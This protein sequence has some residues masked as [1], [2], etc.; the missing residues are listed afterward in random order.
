M[1]N[2]WATKEDV[3]IEGLG[4]NQFIFFFTSEEDKVRILVGSP[5]HYDNSLLLLIEPKGMGE[6]AK[7]DFSKATFWVQIHNIPIVCM[8]QESAFQLGCKIGR[9]KEI[10]LGATGNCLGKF[11]RVRVE[12]DITK[13]LEKGILVDI[14]EQEAIPLI[15][16]Y[17][18]MP[19][20]CY[21]CGKIGHTMREC[22][23]EDPNRV[24]IAGAKGKYADWLK[25]PPPVRNKKPP[26]PT[27]KNT[28]K[29]QENKSPRCPSYPSPSTTKNLTSQPTN[30]SSNPSNPNPLKHQQFQHKLSHV[31]QPSSPSKDQSFKTLENDIPSITATASPSL[32]TQNNTTSAISS[33]S[34][35]PKQYSPTKTQTNHQKYN[36]VKLGKIIQKIILIQLSK[37]K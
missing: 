36:V 9:V 3:A 30:I 26:N 28:P 8:N 16:R 6:I 22:P 7:L 10:D 21:D 23:D 1:S 24:L 20:Y 2:I 5:W 4:D 25:A 14:D 15:L 12:V 17:E 37:L 29:D 11:I 18:R 33:T 32:T 34:P 35:P 19:D 27:P 31:T 13:P